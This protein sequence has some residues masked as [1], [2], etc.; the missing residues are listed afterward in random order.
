MADGLPHDERTFMAGHDAAAAAANAT[1][2]NRTA[3]LGGNGTAVYEEPDPEE[4]QHAVMAFY[5]VVSWRWH[6]GLSWQLR[7]VSSRCTV[8]LPPLPP[9]PPASCGCSTDATCHP[10]APTARPAAAAVCHVLRASRAGGLAQAAQAQVRLLCLFSSCRAAKRA[11]SALGAQHVQHQ[12]L[13]LSQ[14]CA[15]RAMAGHDSPSHLWQP[16]SHLCQ[17]PP[18]C[19]Y[20]LATLVGLW[21]IPPIISL[22]LGAR[23]DWLPFC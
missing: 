23:T 16:P 1:A 15:L 2:L 19:S 7:P 17:P 10:T 13:W 22:Q 12:P 18:P 9:L 14:L 3:A 20:D 4:I 8:P 21:L 11:S 6:A 5:L